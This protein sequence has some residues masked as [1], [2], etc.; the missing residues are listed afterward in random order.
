MDTSVILNG[1]FYVAWSFR[2]QGFNKQWCLP[3]TLAWS[4]CFLLPCPGD[5]ALTGHEQESLHSEK[6]IGQGCHIHVGTLEGLRELKSEQ[7][8]HGWQW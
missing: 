4:V 6:H 7:M 3:Q 1:L 5:S 8:S 2:M